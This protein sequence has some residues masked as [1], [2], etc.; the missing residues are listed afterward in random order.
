MPKKRDRGKKLGRDQVIDNDE[1][2]KRYAAQ[3]QFVEY[4]WGRIG[5][6][7]QRVR[8]ASD[9]GAAFRL[10]PRLEFTLPF[11]E[12]KASCLVNH[13][14][15]PVSIRNLRS[16]QQLHDQSARALTAQW[17]DF[18]NSSQEFESGKANLKISFSEIGALACFFPIFYLLVARDV[19]VQNLQEKFV[20]VQL[21]LK[22]TQQHEE[23]LR[24]KRNAEEAW[25][26]QNEV[27]RLKR[28]R[29]YSVTAINI[30][31]ATAGMP[32]YGWLNSLR[33]CEKLTLEPWRSVPYTYQIFELL[34][35]IVRRMKP[36][37][38]D[39]VQKRLLHELLSE[40]HTLLRETVKPHW[41]D[42]K[43][44]FADCRG[45][46]FT[47]HELPFFVIGG[48]LNYLDT[49]K[50]PMQVEV[51]KHAQAELTLKAKN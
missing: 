2:L 23:E 51:A 19:Q 45:K 46:R 16:T 21:A 32:E 1:L 17:S 34:Q 11:R 33:R 10:V 27:L 28:S 4:N 3:K 15:Q 36:L 18:H 35:Q 44:A 20:D 37:K 5:L 48:F 42:L 50:S 8:K 12:H 26:A 49:P 9:V 25:F 43:R 6:Q 22:K 13:C 7:L 47:R 41:E 39:K 14:S 30:A 29:R 40:Q 38:V 24:Q 31:K